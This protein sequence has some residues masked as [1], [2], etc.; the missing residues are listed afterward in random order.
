MKTA[1]PLR[2]KI[3]LSAAAL[4]LT[5]A[6]E[7]APEVTLTRLDCGGMTAPQSL[8]GFI[9][10]RAHPGLEKQLVASCY[11]IRHGNDL[12]IWDTG[13]SESGGGWDKGTP[14]VDQLRQLGIEPSQIGTIAVSHYHFDHVG[15]INAFPRATL[16]IGKDDWD[17][18]LSDDPPPTAEVGPLKQ[19]RDSGG[20]VDPVRGDRDVFGDG[21]VTMLAMP[22]HTPGHRALLVRLA[23][24]G[25]VLLTGDTAHFKE[26]YADN[27][28][29]TFNA[30]RADTLASFDRFKK[31]AENVDATVII[32]HEPEDVDK[33]PQFPAAAR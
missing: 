2:W 23:E 24:A 32:Q 14:L 12:M 16:L 5:G 15:Q 19:W 26:N 25:P 20:K 4:A 33:L 6:S 29:P 28:V 21:S 31:L 10:T 17:A 13:L 22:G 27:G 7:P 1:N 8:A 11:L 18:A 3:V 30:N 9:D